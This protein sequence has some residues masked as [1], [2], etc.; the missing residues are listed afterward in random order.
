MFGVGAILYLKNSHLLLL[1]YGP[2][3]GTNDREK[4]CFPQI[5]W[6]LHLKKV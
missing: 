6:N 3:Q 2:S 5:W 1:K 4:N